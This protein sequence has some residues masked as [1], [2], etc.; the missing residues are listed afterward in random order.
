VAGEGWIFVWNWAQ[1]IKNT[2]LKYSGIV[3]LISGLGLAVWLNGSLYFNMW[4][5]DPRVW[6]DHSVPETEAAVAVMRSVPNTQCRV[7]AR[8]LNHFTFKFLAFKRLQDCVVLEPD[9]FLRSPGDAWANV[10]YVLDPAQEQYRRALQNAFPGSRETTLRYS[11]GEPIVYWVDVPAE[12]W[13]SV[14]PTRTGFNARWYIHDQNRTEI[15]LQRTELILEYTNGNDFP[16][17]PPG[18]GGQLWGDWR[19]AFK[20]VRNERS[21]LFVSSMD[22]VEI[23]ID[24]KGWRHFVGDANDDLDLPPGNHKIEIRYFIHSNWNNHLIL[25]VQSSSAGSKTREITVEPGE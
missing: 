20:S 1:E 14:L 13:K 9:S 16:I 22:L 24:A 10:R 12:R 23:N 4:A 7:S 8:F 25:Q 21:R 5:S 15:L 3:L 19:G 17:I 2:V 11:W 6:K 18:I